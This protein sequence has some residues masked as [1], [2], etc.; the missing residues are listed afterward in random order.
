MN[1]TI[2][3]VHG[4]HE[5]RPANIPSY[6][7][8]EWNGGTAWYEEEF[9][10]L[11]FAKDGCVYSLEEI[12]YLFIGGA[13]SADRHYRLMHRY[14]WW[15]DEQPS[16]EIKAFVEKQISEKHFDVV[17]SH[18]CPFKYEPAE[19]FLPMLDQSSVDDSTE[20]WLDKI[21]DS[22]AYRA[23]LCGHWHINK[24]F[25]TAYDQYS[26]AVE[27]VLSGQI[28]DLNE[29]SKILD[30]LCDFGD[31]ERF[32]ELYS[33]VCKHVYYRYSELVGDYVNIFRSLWITDDDTD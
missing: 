17:L 2:F 9:P 21:E 6:T 10:N 18:T 15:D 4:N 23:W 13:Y 11:L 25:D 14:G 8:K 33:K 1:L 29:V 32:V 24:R 19:A 7:T 16:D 26:A 27:L 22:I 31:E 30:G 28:A 12:N 5:M 20:R 3:C